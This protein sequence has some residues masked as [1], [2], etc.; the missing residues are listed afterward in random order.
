MAQFQNLGDLI[1]R[2]RDLSK[3]AII[4]LGGEETPC[5]YT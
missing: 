3:V 5:E 1:V 4:D 2:D